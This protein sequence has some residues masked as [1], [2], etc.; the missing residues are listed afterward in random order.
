VTFVLFLH[1]AAA[2]LTIGPVVVAMMAFARQVAA[3][4]VGVLRFLNRVTRLYGAASVVVFLLGL[5]L[6]T[7]DDDSSFRD[8]WV[9]S[10]MTLYVVAIGLLF[11]L[12]E[13]DQR[14][15]IERIDA[16][17]PASIRG[18]R[19]A[20]VGGAVSLIWLVIVLLMVWQPGS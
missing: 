6:V 18:R 3:G 9:S 1:I 13:R 11:G 17:E 20:G 4:D 15:A 10:S 2:I 12:V 7:L 8:F 19:I 16:G 5:W 14:R